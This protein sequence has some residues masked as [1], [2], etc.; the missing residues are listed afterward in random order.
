MQYDKGTLKHLLNVLE[1]IE[2]RYWQIPLDV[3]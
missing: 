3:I 2:K 1:E